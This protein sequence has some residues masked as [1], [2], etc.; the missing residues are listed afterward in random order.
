VSVAPQQD[1]EVEQL[2]SALRAGDEQARE[3]LF[4]LL[5]DRLRH[6]A[7]L[8]MRNERDDHTLGPTSLVHDAYLRLRK[9]GFSCADGL[10]FMRLA[11]AAMRRILVDSARRRAARRR[12]V[13]GREETAASAAAARHD[14][15]TLAL[16]VAL[17]RLGARDDQL[18][19]IVELRFYTG[20]DVEETAATLDVSTATI[21]RG[22]RTAKA[23][24]HRELAQ[25]EAQA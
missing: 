6:V 13:A 21:K 24:L 7:A 11:S 18:R 4:A 17:E 15:R 9:S 22:W 14:E 23:W 3:R 8:H 20:L 2:L 1:D 5:Y 25:A 16:E 19:R 10:E 12:A